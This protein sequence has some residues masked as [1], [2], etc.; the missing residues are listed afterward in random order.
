MLVR[1]SYVLGGRAMEI[2]Y[3]EDELK[4]YLTMRSKPLRNIRCWWTVMSAA[5]SAKWTPFADGDQ[6]FDSRN[7]GASGTGRGPFRGFDCR[8]S[9]ST[10][11]HGG[12]GKDFELYLKIG[13]G[14]K[15]GGLDQ[16]SICLD[17]MMR[18]IV[19]RS[20]PG[21]AGRCLL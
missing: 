3:N 15:S 17:P 20:T 4:N 19:S 16:Y 21:P 13:P 1:P 8:L 7:H 11:D 14:L 9:A 6:Y 2:V 12:A 5:G 18:Y 10:L